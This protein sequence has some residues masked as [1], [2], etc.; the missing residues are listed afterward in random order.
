MTKPNEPNGA[1]SGVA[2]IKADFMSRIFVTDAAGH[3]FALPIG[4]EHN[5]VLAAGGVPPGLELVML[6]G[7]CHPDYRHLVASSLLLFQLVE[8][9]KI[10]F[11]L[12]S[13]QLQA[14]G[15]PA[16]MNLG[17]QFETMAA[18]LNLAQRQAIEG[19]AALYANVQK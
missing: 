15:N 7:Q 10:M 11:E 13:E 18:N 2:K 17:V 3:I 8:Q 4:P 5:A 6:A 1:S 12:H 14:V 9:A 16:L 19:G